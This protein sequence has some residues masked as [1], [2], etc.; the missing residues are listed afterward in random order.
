MFVYCLNAPVCYSD[1]AGQY[2]GNSIRAVAVEE[3]YGVCEKG[4]IRKK[5]IEKIKK[6][7]Q[8]FVDNFVFSAGIGLGLFGGVIATKYLNVD[9]GIHWDLWRI[10]YQNG[11][12]EIYE[13]V[14]QG[15]DASFLFFIFGDI[16]EMRHPILSGPENWEKTQS[17]ECVAQ[18]GV[19]VYFFAGGTITLGYDLNSFLYDIC[20]IWGIR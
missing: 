5:T 17:P 13:Y 16:E 2:A 18:I 6:S 8:A 4:N 14:K 11:Q 20:E 7:T 10:S 19:S 1:P 9:A 15:L 3:G 12:F